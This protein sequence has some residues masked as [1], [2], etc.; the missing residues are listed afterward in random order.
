[1]STNTVQQV[2]CWQSFAGPVGTVR[3]GEKLPEDHPLVHQARKMFIDADTPEREWPNFY[4]DLVE[5]AAE[6]RRAELEAERAVFDEVARTNPILIE[7]PKTM[8][9]VQDFTGWHNGVAALIRKGS[10]AAENDPV[11]RQNPDAWKAA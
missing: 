1:M 10:T 11:V 2:V 5:R 9:C 4:D 6:Q 7:A 3:R 8:R